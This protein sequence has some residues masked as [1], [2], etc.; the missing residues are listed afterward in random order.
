MNYFGIQPLLA[1]IRYIFLECLAWMNC[2]VWKQCTYDITLSCIESKYNADIKCFGSDFSFFLILLKFVFVCGDIQY[3][4]FQ[5]C[6]CIIIDC[7]IFVWNVYLSIV[8]STI[9]NIK[10]IT[11]ILFVNILYLRDVMGKS[12]WKQFTERF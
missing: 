7:T 11:S 2:F 8:P 9:I 12:F 4:V 3:T 5:G 10:M 6:Y 1:L